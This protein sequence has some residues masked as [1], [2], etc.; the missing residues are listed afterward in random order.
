M[1]RSRSP[2]KTLYGPVGAISHPTF[3]SSTNDL[4]NVTNTIVLPV[5]DQYPTAATIASFG[6][7]N[8]PK[9]VKSKTGCYKNQPTMMAALANG[10]G[11]SI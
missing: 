11:A 10:V 6:S 2:T 8:I 7:Q 3:S 1:G 4:R 5:I 9:A